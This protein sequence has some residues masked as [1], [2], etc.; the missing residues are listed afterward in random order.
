M[1]K[2]YYNGQILTI[3]D[4]TPTA[5]AVVVENGKI[6]YVGDCETAKKYNDNFEKIDLGK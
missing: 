4:E 6:A 3:D 2:I 1:N 5:S